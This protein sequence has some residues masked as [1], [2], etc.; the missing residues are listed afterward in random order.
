M[1][2]PGTES[3]E[4]LIREAAERRLSIFL[5]PIV[6]ADRVWFLV[7]LHARFPDHIRIRDYAVEENTVTPLGQVIRG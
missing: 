6:E 7:Q 4:A 3:F 5:T 1:S 2:E